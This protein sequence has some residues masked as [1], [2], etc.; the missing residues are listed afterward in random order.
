MSK[1]VECPK[2]PGIPG[3]AAVLDS[4][5]LIKHLSPFALRWQWGTLQAIRLR[6][7]KWH[8]ASRC[9]FEI[10][11]KAAAGWQELIGKVYAENR[12]D[13]YK[14]MEEITQAGFGP[15]DEFS[16]P[17]P[18]A[19]ISGLNLLLQEKIQGP[20]AKQF[21]LTGNECDRTA[22]AE[23]CA[24]WLAKF[25][26]VAPPP[27]EALE[28]AATDSIERWSRKI[29]RLGEPFAGLAS[30]LSKRL[31]DGAAAVM[32]GM[33]NC[34]HHGT[35]NYDQDILNQ[36][37]IIAFDFDHYDV[38]DPCRDVARF[39]V[40]LQLLGFKHLGSIQALDSAAAVFVETYQAHSP[41]RVAA[42]LPWYR[43]WTC[44]QN[45]KYEA[46]RGAGTFDDGMRAFL[47]EGL[48][49]LE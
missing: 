17:R 30:Q 27:A 9:T 33:E 6:I 3:L 43:A 7:L 22:A 25:H 23:R 34:A 14:T 24:R 35:Y 18:I 49:V 28:P 31:E 5:E 32:E 1:F 40:A 41:F 16:I 10:G 21:F 26:A 39:L 12:S 29:A 46:D 8:R 15:G 20:R 48:R 19:Y 11:L 44:L 13:V 4:A 42:R 38:A 36:D 45:C 37:R 2:D 47:G